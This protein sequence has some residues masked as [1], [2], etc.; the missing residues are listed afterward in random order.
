[1]MVEMLILGI[2]IL[3]VAGIVLTLWVY[4][5]LLS[6][7]NKLQEATKNIRDGNLDFTLRM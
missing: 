3:M 2:T 1:M 5:S 6:P 7:L 4:R